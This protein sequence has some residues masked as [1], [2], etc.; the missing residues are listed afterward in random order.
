LSALFNKHNNNNNN[1][2][3]GGDTFC[4]AQPLYADE[5]YRP[6]IKTTMESIIVTEVNIYEAYSEKQ[7]ATFESNGAKFV[8]LKRGADL[9]QHRPRPIELFRDRPFSI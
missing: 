5:L 8:G 7:N 2:Q 3:F 4:D 1:C 6:I 9:Y